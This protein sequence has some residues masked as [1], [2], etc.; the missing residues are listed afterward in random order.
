MVLL[1]K[2]S[3]WR[4]VYAC[5]V[6]DSPHT[7]RQKCQYALARTGQPTRPNRHRLLHL[8]HCMPLVGSSMGRFHLSL[9]RRTHHRSP[10]ALFRPHLRL[11]CHPTLE[12]GNRYCPTPNHPKTQH[13]CWD[14][15]TVLRGLLNDDAGILHSHLVP[16]D[17]RCQCH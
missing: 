2:S 8:K 7:W 1:H 16:G 17:Q 11:H 15:V 6:L 5:L 9:E 4:G 13:S 12:A 3:H 14:V 10:C